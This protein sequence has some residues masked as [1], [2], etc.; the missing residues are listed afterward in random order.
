MITW[1]PS[2]RG[3]KW[4]G[5]GAIFC[6]PLGFT[7]HPL[8]DRWILK[9]L[10]FRLAGALCG[11]YVLLNGRVRV[12]QPTKQQ[13]IRNLQTGIMNLHSGKPT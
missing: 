7:H 1:T 5:K 13:K 8:E 10:R 6:N 11:R 2:F 9:N 3:A 4:M 12:A